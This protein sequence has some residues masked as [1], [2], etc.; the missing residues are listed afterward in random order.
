[1]NAVSLG[2][3]QGQVPLPPSPRLMGGRGSLGAES[4]RRGSM[5][6]D[7]QSWPGLRAIATSLVGAW[8]R[9]GAHGEL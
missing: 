8:G 4:G 2:N 9:M 7:K 1:M 6:L 5:R 3:G